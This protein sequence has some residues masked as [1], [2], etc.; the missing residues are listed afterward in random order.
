MICQRLQTDRSR[1]YYYEDNHEGAEMSEDVKNQ[2]LLKSHERTFANWLVVAYTMGIR[3]VCPIHWW[4][5]TKC[6]CIWLWL[7][8][9]WPWCKG[10]WVHSP[11]VTSGCLWLLSENFS[12]KSRA[13]Y[14]EDN[15]EGAEMSEDVKNQ[16]KNKTHCTIFLFG[17]FGFREGSTGWK[18]GKEERQQKDGCISI[19]IFKSISLLSVFNS[20]SLWQ[21]SW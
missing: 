14:C 15:H 3:T 4:T 12:D 16:A 20:F 6:R 13:Y 11:V 18:Q 2:V 8:V 9:E 1:A 7:E 10:G 5:V 21:L 17:S 19:T